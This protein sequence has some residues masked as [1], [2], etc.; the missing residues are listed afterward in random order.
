M[1]DPKRPVKTRGGREAR[2]ICTDRKGD[3]YS[4]IALVVERAGS[5]DIYYYL[6]DGTYSGAPHLDLINI[7]HEEE[8][9]AALTEKGFSNNWFSSSRGSFVPDDQTTPG[10][11]IVKV[12]ITEIE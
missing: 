12:R 5:E 11:R 6:S 3:R 10:T 2:I 8:R 7:P 4:I 1:F 9:W